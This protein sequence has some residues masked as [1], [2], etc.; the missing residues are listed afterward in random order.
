VTAFDR[1]LAWRALAY[2]ALGSALV[3]SIMLL[4]EEPLTTGSQRLAR[5]C[6]FA[7]AIAALG[8]L[9]SLTQ[10]RARGELVALAALG[11]SP[12]R[13]ARGASVVAWGLGLVAVMLVASPAA[14]VSAVFPALRPSAQWTPTERSFHEYQQGV[15]V[16]SK[17]G[18]GFMPSAAVSTPVRHGQSLAA[19]LAVGPVALVLPIWVA[20]AMRRWMRVAGTAATLTLLLVLLHAVAAGRLGAP[21]LVAVAFPL[22]L[23][24]LVATRRQP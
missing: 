11:A 4:T 20:S 10:A 24:A 3:F 12:L 5:L 18:L 15:S 1:M 17:G 19:A 8:S 23:Q 14:D 2:S 21:W 9:L 22:A 7:P 16:T 6:V 13:L